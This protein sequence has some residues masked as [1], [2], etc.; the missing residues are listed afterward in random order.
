[1]AYARGIHPLT[2]YLELCRL[3][4]QLSILD[5]AVLVPPALPPYNHDDLGG[6]FGRV[7]QY[8]D[9]LLECVEIPTYEQ[10]P[11]IGAGLRLQVG[12][13]KPTW[14]EPGWAL[15]IGVTSSLSP[16][17]C[18]A[19]LLGGGLRLFAE[20]LPDS[21]WGLTQATILEDGAIGL[22]YSRA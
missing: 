7:K 20:G 17:E 21:A 3:V 5:A 2:A 16:E 1:M 4:G 11:F 9:H 15:Y 18:L 10:R 13:D 14:L 6:C 22:H 8:L 12:L 19:L